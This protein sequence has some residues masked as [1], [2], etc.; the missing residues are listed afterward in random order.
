MI[1]VFILSFCPC[2][3]S[4]C[5]CFIIFFFSMSKMFLCISLSILNILI[6]VF[7]WLYHEVHSYSVSRFY[8]LFCLASAFSCL[9]YLSVA[10]SSSLSVSISFSL[11]SWDPPSSLYL[12]RRTQSTS[13]YATV[14]L[15]L[16]LDLRDTTNPVIRWVGSISCFE[17]VFLSARLPGPT[18]SYKAT[19]SDSESA[20]TL[21]RPHGGGGWPTSAPGFQ[22]W[23]WPGLSSVLVQTAQQLQTATVCCQSWKLSDLHLHPCSNF[24]SLFICDP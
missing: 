15:L 1:S 9:G 7:F 19:T 10:F 22:L 11:F 18:E 13:V 6:L 4:G 8:W 16:R 3:N 5:L 24:V 12:L 23:I 21:F 17:T 2:F 20:V 14:S